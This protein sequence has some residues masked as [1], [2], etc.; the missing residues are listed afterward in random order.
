[1]KHIIKGAEPEEFINWKSQD[2]MYLR[3]RPNWN[4]PKQSI[5]NI[6]RLQIAKEQ[7]FICCYCERRIE[8]NDFHLEH[9]KPRENFP[10]EQLEYENLLCSCQL[11]LGSGEPRFCGNSKGSWY[12]ENL[13]I[14]PLQNDCEE[15]FAYTL[16]GH[17]E[18]A[19]EDDLATITTIEKLKLHK[20]KLNN[21]RKAA[22]DPFIDA[23]LS[24]T[25]LEQFVNGYLIEK[26]S[27][28]GK[29]N[30]F[31]TTIKYLFGKEKTQTA[32]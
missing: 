5:K 2:K 10:F 3:N 18:P 17:I 12:N 30:E 29:Y 6:L 32:M 9:L 27:N 8:N 16:D 11:E 25:E 1:M 22:I 19:N 15:K 14:T 4:R 23:S 13:L 20:D 31:F 28:G 7:G 24:E 26:E 21:W